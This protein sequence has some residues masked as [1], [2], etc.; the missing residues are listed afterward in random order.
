MTGHACVN[1]GED[2][3]SLSTFWGIVE[4]ERTAISKVSNDQI[5]VPRDPGLCQMVNESRRQRG[6]NDDHWK[7]RSKFQ[8]DD[9]YDKSER[10]MV[11]NKFTF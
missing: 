9:G 2:D 8:G 6:Q 10:A 4:S 7:G 5:F 1:L 11:E 3:F